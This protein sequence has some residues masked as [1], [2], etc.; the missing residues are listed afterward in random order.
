[1]KLKKKYHHSEETK[2]KIRKIRKLYIGSKASNWKGGKIL[3][4]GYLYIYSPTHPNKTK[5][6]YVCEHRLVM[7]KHMGR[8]L[9]KKEVVHHINGDITDN[10]IENLMLYSSTGVHA[11]ENHIKRGKDGKFKK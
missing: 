2:E 8:I 4:G 10:R 7:E 3:V 1:M 9:T 5:D 6:G 11:L